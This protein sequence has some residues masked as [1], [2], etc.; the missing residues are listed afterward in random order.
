[1]VGTGRKRER[2]GEGRKSHGGIDERRR[3]EHFS[4]KY[5]SWHEIRVKI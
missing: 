5:N 3:E 4:K 2:G 1:M